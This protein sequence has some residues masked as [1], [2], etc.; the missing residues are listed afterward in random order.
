MLPPKKLLFPPNSICIDANVAVKSGSPLLNLIEKEFSVTVPWTVMHEVYNLAKFFPIKFGNWY[1]MSWGHKIRFHLCFFLTISGN[2]FKT[3]LIE[4]FGNAQGKDKM[5]DLKILLE[6]ALWNQAVRNS[7]S[8]TPGILLSSNYELFK[9][10]PA[11]LERGFA[12]FGLETPKVVRPAFLFSDGNLQVNFN[13]Q[14][15]CWRREDAGA[16]VGWATREKNADL[17]IYDAKNARNLDTLSVIEVNLV[18]VIIV[19]L[20]I[21]AVAMARDAIFVG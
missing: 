8:E 21:M 12:Y 19:D 6:V 9:S 7:G 2:R 17:S 4:I 5:N 3:F 1:G 13:I 10:D 11:T 15:S 18:P 20:L 16:A 14:N